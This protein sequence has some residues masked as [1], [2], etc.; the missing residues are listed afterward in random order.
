MGIGPIIVRGFWVVAYLLALPKGYA[1]EPAP[2]VGQITSPPSRIVATVYGAAG[3]VAGSLSVL[4]TGSARWMIDCGALA[5]EREGEKEKRPE[6]VAQQST[7]LPVDGRSIA[8]VFITHAHTDHVGRLPLLVEGGFRGPLYLTD[9]TAELLPLMLRMQV[10]YDEGRPRSWTWSKQAYER[11][12]TGQRPVTVHWH[13][14]CPYRNAIAQKNLESA[15]LSFNE[16]AARFERQDPAVAVTPCRR[17]TDE[18]VASIVALCRRVGYGKPAEVAP[19][20]SVTLRDAGHIPGSA[21]VLFEVR[22]GDKKRRV[23]FSGDVGNDLSPL[24]AGPQPAPDVD[25]VFMETTYGPTFRDPSVRNERAQFRR[26]VAEVVGGGG[27]A[28]IP[29]FALDRTQKILHE[30]HLAQ[31]EG[32]LSQRVPI[33][34]TSSTALEITGIYRQHRQDGW[35]RDLPAGDPS[36]WSPEGLRKSA[37]LPKNLPYPSVLLTTSGML[38]NG[39]SRRLVSRLASEKST[40]I[41]LVGYQDPASPGGMLMRAVGLLREGTRDQASSIRPAAVLPSQDLSKP[42]AAAVLELDGQR[43]PV[44]AAVQSYRCFSAHGDAKE[45]DAW[46]SEIHR[47][48]AVILVHGGTWELT[49]RAEQLV[50]QGWRDVRIAK[51]GEPIDLMRTD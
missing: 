21:S 17:C 12:R 27:V 6:P 44:R 33:Y 26:S 15:R 19:G 24:F 39:W 51:P 18:E 48:A 23:L 8:A 46:L 38:D 50:K 1:D 31:Q 14:G 7:L 43:I 22:V 29:A 40:T 41:F 34:C 3:E 4:D 45:M 47:T 10:R 35:F 30:L 42:P 5:P 49:A 2:A 9:A 20:V 28:W 13:A 16:L 25:A 32:M 36:A 37:A 11:A